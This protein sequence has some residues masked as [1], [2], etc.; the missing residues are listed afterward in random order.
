MQKLANSRLLHYE[1]RQV[2]ESK[3]RTSTS[4]QHQ[5]AKPKCRTAKSEHPA[6]K[7]KRRTTIRKRFKFCNTTYTVYFYIIIFPILRLKT[8]NFPRSSS[9]SQINIYSI[10]PFKKSLIPKLMIS[11]S[12][13]FQ[14]FRI[15]PP[16]L[17]PLIINFTELIFFSSSPTTRR[18]LP[19]NFV[20][21][22]QQFVL[23]PS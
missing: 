14:K 17:Q 6:T 13:Q 20:H 7:S 19:S 11:P 22:I 1:D 5:T 15:F 2:S 12:R 16:D 18:P 9:N 10:N 8:Y 23:Y 3:R 4:T 21:Q